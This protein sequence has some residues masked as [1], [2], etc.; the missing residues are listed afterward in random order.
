MQ[1]STFSK[2][3]DYFFKPP[4]GDKQIRFLPEYIHYIK[5]STPSLTASSSV[6]QQQQQ[7]Q[8]NNGRRNKFI[9]QAR[10]LDRE[11][12]GKTAAPAPVKC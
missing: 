4:Q 10:E 1:I 5:R 11:V 2:A 8:Q 9:T 12:P 3:S 7:Q 6:E